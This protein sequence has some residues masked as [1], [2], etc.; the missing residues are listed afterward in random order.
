MSEKDP[1]KPTVTDR[2]FK[3]M[4]EIPSEYGGNI[5]AYE[6]SGAEYPA[7]WVRIY[8]KFHGYEEEKEAV[9][10]LTLESAA[11]LRDQID[12]LIKKHYQVA[13]D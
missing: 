2:G 10:H 5:R 11:L 8:Q 9:V 13:D 6:S 7:I 12:Y 3:H 1:M 4:D